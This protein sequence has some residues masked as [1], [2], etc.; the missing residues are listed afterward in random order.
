MAGRLLSTAMI[1]LVTHT[2]AFLPRHARSS[3][4]TSLRCPGGV[5]VIFSMLHFTIYHWRPNRQDIPGGLSNVQKLCF[6]GDLCNIFLMRAL[7]PS[8]LYLPLSREPFL[9][10][11]IINNTIYIMAGITDSASP[12][13]SHRVYKTPWPG[14]LRVNIQSNRGKARAYQVKHVLR[15]IERLE[16]RHDPKK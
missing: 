5:T 4:G 13:N 11:D 3:A 8:L 6:F 10:D 1:W 16:V 12:G 15:A 2:T 9:T 7:L 14:D